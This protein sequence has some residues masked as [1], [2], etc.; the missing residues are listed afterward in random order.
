MKIQIKKW[1]NSLALRIPKSLALDT[2][3]KI[4]KFVELSTDEHKKKIIVTPIDEQE[5]S[6][7]KL[8]AGITK[9]NIH[10]EF[11]TGRS[12][13]NEVWIG[14]PEEQNFVIKSLIMY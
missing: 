9:D 1:G 8:L 13:G 4:N 14:K 11:E 6:L 10:K 3:L 2:N 5:Y 12:V 7:E